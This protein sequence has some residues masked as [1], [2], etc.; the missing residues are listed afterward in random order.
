MKKELSN[1]S[2]L[3]FLALIG[4]FVLGFL[5][6]SASMSE[7]NFFSES[8]KLFFGR[9]E[10]VESPEPI[11]Y[12]GKNPQ[13]ATAVTTEDFVQGEVESAR[14][15]LV[16]YLDLNCI[17][18][19]RFHETMEA[20]MAEFEGEVAWVIRHYPLMGSVK[21]AQAAE[22]VGREGGSDKFWEFV[23]AYYQEMVPVTASEDEKTSLLIAKAS[24]LDVE[25]ADCLESDEIKNA[26]QA[27][28]QNAQEIG[29]QG[30][31][32]TVLIF[33]ET[34]EKEVLAGAYSTADMLEILGTYL[35]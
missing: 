27:E 4:V 20:V 26:V 9:D 23:Q 30:T 15:I 11:S 12:R 16:E 33:P 8:K 34:G 5:I 35:R 13:A 6:A 31:P 18:C 14:M 17:Y 7:Q 25:I 3:L 10:V 21:E 22:C 24:N 2:K 19:A 32:S 1:K 28:Y 29:L